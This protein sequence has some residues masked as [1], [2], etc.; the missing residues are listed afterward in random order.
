[1]F[2]QGINGVDFIVCNTDNQALERSPVPTKIALGVAL[3]QGLGAGSIP[4]VGKESAIESIEEIRRVLSTRT[5]MVFITAGMGGGTGTGAAPV[6]AA[7]A[8]E[9]GI[10]TVGIVTIPF[11]FEGSKRRNQAQSGIEEM[12]KNVDTLLVISNE[13]LREIYG[14]L[15]MTAA[16]GRADDILKTAAKGIADIITTSMHVNTDF[17]DIE[18]VLR[19]SGVAIMG[20]ALASGEDRAR[21]AAES[22][23]ASPLLNDNNISG[24]RHVLVN[25]TCGAGDNELTM[26]EF[27]EINEYLQGIA[28]NTAEI[29]QGYGVDENM[30]GDEIKVTIVATGFSRNTELGFIAQA[31][32]KKVHHLVAPENNTEV[33]SN[34]QAQVT[35]T[36]SAPV[37]NETPSDGRVVYQLT[38][39]VVTEEVVNEVIEETP[40]P[41]PVVETPLMEVKADANQR[42][43]HNLFDDEM[44]SAESTAAPA[45]S[46]EPQ[47]S[48]E[49]KSKL[50]QERIEK[51]K[52][53]NFSKKNYK[54]ME[55]QPAYLRRGVELNQI[56][57]SADTNVSR[58]TLS[59]GDDQRTEIRPNNSFLTDSVD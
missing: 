43:V 30:I 32:A 31:P 42:I 4:E 9:M 41:T 35:P 48:I 12:K 2:R 8:K 18:T 40:A 13:K 26:D 7:A 3:T 27:G 36:Q 55:S 58:F 38:D 20:S 34:V 52:R 22:A 17:A 51:L 59:E 45:I 15:K 28:G 46:T 39:E 10:L 49:D 56:P 54:E 1:M 23:L 44:P 19:D 14:N 6:I 53:F 5:K 21:N 47:L 16:F 33:E 25:I 57:D 37:L 24:A 29:I 11:S 50:A